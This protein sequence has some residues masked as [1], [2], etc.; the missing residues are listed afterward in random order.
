MFFLL[1]F[2]WLLFFPYFAFS[3][4]LI[5]EVMFNP[6][7]ND[8]EREWIEIFNS[9]NQ[10]IE[11][12]KWKIYDGQNH[13][14][15]EK[16][17]LSP[18]EILVI[19]QNKDLFFKEYPNFNAK[20]IE[21]NF[22]LKNKQGVISLLNKNKEIIANVFYELNCGGNDNGYSIIYINNSCQE[23][24]IKG[25][26][27]RS[28]ITLEGYKDNDSPSLKTNDKNLLNNFYL[29]N[30]EK[31]L[32]EDYFN[33][34]KEESHPDIKNNLNQIK[35]SEKKSRLIISE[36]LPNPAGND[37]GRE[38]IELF[39]DSQ[40][41]INLNKFTLEIGNKKIKLKGVI[42]PKDYFVISNK[43]YNFYIRNKGENLSLY[44]DR[45]KI[46]SINY[47]GRSPQGKS[48]SRLVNGQ[49][50][51]MQPTP[52]KENR[53]EEFLLDNKNRQNYFIKNN[54]EDKIPL[55]LI[56]SNLSAN[57]HRQQELNDYLLFF[58]FIFLISL[59]LFFL[60]R[61]NFTET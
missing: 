57:V 10:S 49:W 45:E 51:F 14:L 59:I 41:E 11:I 4:I 53:D 46:F 60:I 39:N 35:E 34:K 47:Q 55:N 40:I 1:F 61:K 6:E 23:N 44:L 17:I 27:P 43:D 50:L 20:L 2:F 7:G 22:S 21:A 15:K 13:P 48:F 5:T 12:D 31:S 24:K 18:Q 54:K 8:K 28:L 32:K 37:Q 56:E 9:S 3:Q 30:L 26:T 16:I 42:K 52:G 58:L 19:V 36:F 38:F 25:G 29:E 33:L